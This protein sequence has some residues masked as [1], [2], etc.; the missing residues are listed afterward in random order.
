MI[1][2]SEISSATLSLSMGSSP[3]S[4]RTLADSLRWMVRS[5]FQS[6]C[7]RML[8]SVVPGMVHWSSTRAYF[9]RGLDSPFCV[10]FARVVDAHP[11]KSKIM[12]GDSSFIDT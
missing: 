3:C 6:V 12:V 10:S 9:W 7:L 1:S 2:G 4:L 11:T 5:L 8:V